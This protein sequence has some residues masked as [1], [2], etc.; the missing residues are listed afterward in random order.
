MARIP[1][2][3]HH[4]HIASCMAENGLD[5][6]VIGV[7]FD[8]TGYGTDGKIWG[9]EFLVARYA[10]FERYAH[11][12]YFPLAGGDAAV[13]EP[14]RAAV[15]LAPANELRGVP[16]SSVRVVRRMIETGLNTVETSSCGRLFDAVAVDHRA[17]AGDH[18]RRPGRDR[19]GD[20]RGC[21]RGETSI[22]TTDWISGRR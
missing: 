12:R 20:D 21:S 3:H 16:E 4:A 7:A 14:W 15:A 18:L 11:F 19:T 22:P 17:A 9:G 6:D 13:R 10:G 8:G 1:V 2:Q 5:G